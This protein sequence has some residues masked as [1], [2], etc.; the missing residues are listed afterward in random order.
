MAGLIV[1]R[2]VVSV[3]VHMPQYF[4]NSINLVMPACNK[5]QRDLNS[6]PFRRSFNLLLVLRVDIKYCMVHSQCVH[7]PY[8][9]CLF[10]DRYG[11]A[12]LFHLVFSYNFELRIQLFEHKAV[13][14]PGG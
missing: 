11:F 10:T 13:N 6:S 3:W 1:A 8:C 7:D 14:I 12:G 2:L 5:I 9:Y 4:H